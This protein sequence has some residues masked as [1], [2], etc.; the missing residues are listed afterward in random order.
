MAGNANQIRQGIRHS[1]SIGLSGP[2]Y[3][4]GPLPSHDHC[5]YEVALQ[6]V[7]S[8]LEKGSYSSSHKQWDTIRKLRSAYSNQMR[9]SAISNFSA[10]SMADNKG[11]YSRLA[12]DPCGSLWFQ[13]F[14]EGCKSRMGQD[15]R[16]NRALSS[17]L[18]LELLSRVER[19]AVSAPSDSN[20]HRWVMAGAYFCFSY[21]LSL[22][23]SEGLLTD[24][25][26]MEEH[27]ATRE[28]WVVVPLLG[29]FKGEHHTKQH[30]MTCVNTTDSG[31]R[32][33]LWGS[34]LLAIH[35]SQG[36]NRGPAFLNHKVSN[37]RQRN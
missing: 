13:R 9:A 7:L 26:G 22:R 36:R 3:P 1:E 25:E 34:R 32:I 17:E 11:S 27:F 21:V 6:A 19:K 10:L 35:I 14:M 24:L 15:S 28:D 33:R 2:Y 20:R 8:L 37:R 5:G 16:P 23:G 12:P 4:P 18:M 29:R 30:L 31:I